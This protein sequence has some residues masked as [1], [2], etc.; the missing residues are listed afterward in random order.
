M[1]RKLASILL[2][3]YFIIAKKYVKI[4]VNSVLGD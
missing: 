1:N 3:W 4:Y 2:H